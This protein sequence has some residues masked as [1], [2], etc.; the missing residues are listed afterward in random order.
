VGHCR[1]DLSDTGRS[2]VLSGFGVIVEEIGGSVDIWLIF[3]EKSGPGWWEWKAYRI[4]SGRDM[5]ADSGPSVRVRR[6]RP[7]SCIRVR[8][9][10]AIVYRAAGGANG[11]YK[12][13]SLR[14]RV[15]RLFGVHTPT[16]SPGSTAFSASLMPPWTD[17]IMRRPSLLD[18]QSPHTS[19]RRNSPCGYYRF[20]VT[21]A[22]CSALH[23]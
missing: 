20:L 23:S 21:S 3:C 4:S 16:L 14:P 9:G 6:W 8:T 5:I 22:S 2:C 19:H 15:G 12:S 10:Y 7:V 11:V 1:L 18:V 13:W 17:L